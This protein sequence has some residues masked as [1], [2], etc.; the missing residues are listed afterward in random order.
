MTHS[1]FLEIECKDTKDNLIL[2]E[3]DQKGVI[4]MYHSFLPLRHRIHKGSKRHGKAVC[5]TLWTKGEK[6]GGGFLGGFSLPDLCKTKLQSSELRIMCH[7]K[8]KSICL[9]TSKQ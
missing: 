8:G 5:Y 9:I 7:R 6:K 2:E 4:F 3:K 1:F